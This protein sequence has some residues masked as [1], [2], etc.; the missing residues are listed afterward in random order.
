MIYEQH[1]RAHGRQLLIRSLPKCYKKRNIAIVGLP[2]SGTSWLAKAVSLTEKTA[3]YFEPDQEYDKKCLYPYVHENQKNSSLKQHILKTFNGD[4]VNEYVIAEQGIKEI[5]ASMVAKNLLVKWVRFSFCLEWIKATFP[6]LVFVQ[7]IRH[8]VPLFLSW[9]SASRD[10]DPSYALTTILTQESLMEGP[11]KNYQY[12]MTSAKTPWEKAGAF[13]GAST[14][15]QYHAQED[16][17][18]FQTHEWYCENPNER[19]RWLIN[20]LNLIENSSL[21]SFL[22]ENRRKNGPGYGQSRS[23]EGEIKKWYGKIDTREY[24]DLMGVINQFDFPFYEYFE[25]SPYD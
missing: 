1:I 3:Y 6:D 20:E 8:P 11:L 19:I 13:W 16:K 10:W 24:R 18:L 4:I 9:A 14:Y 15:M 17:R 21:Q 25:K 12:L 23:S 22:S 2:R 5:L 7:I